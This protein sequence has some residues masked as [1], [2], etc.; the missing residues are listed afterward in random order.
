MTFR[1]LRQHELHALPPEALLRYIVRARTARDPEAERDAGRILA[2]PN[3]SYSSAGRS[4]AR[5]PETPSA[6]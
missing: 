6:T 2:R 3:T 5:Y 4:L 1:R